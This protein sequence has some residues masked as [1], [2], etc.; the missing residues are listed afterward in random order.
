M[1][2][3][4]FT[5][6]PLPWI[7][8]IPQVSI[9]RHQDAGCAKAALQGVMAAKGGLQ[10]R[11]PSRIRSEVLDGAKTC[12]FDLNG[13]SEAG[14]RWA[15]VDLD[16]AG[17]AHAVLTTDVGAGKADR[18]PQEVGQQHARFGL[19]ADGLAVEREANDMPP[20]GAQARHRR[21]SPIVSRPIRR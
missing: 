11:E 14:T 4:E 16:G 12:A 15:A 1:S 3:Q 17:T 20:V 13:E 8:M 2:A 5:Q 6:L 10:D 9:K 19:G 18:V 21:A 7:G